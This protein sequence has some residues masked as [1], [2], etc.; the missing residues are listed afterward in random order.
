MSITT[1]YDTIFSKYGNGL[2]VPYL[3]A[4][5]SRESDMNPL[6][7]KGTTSAAKGL[8]QVIPVVLK[9]YNEEHGTKLKESD[10]YTPIVNVAIA[11]STMKH[12]L[13]SYSMSPPLAEVDWSSK[14]WVELFTF[15]WNA[16]YSLAAG[17]AKVATE[18]SKAGISDSDVTIETVSSF[19]SKLIQDGNNVSSNLTNQAK[20]SWCK[21]VVSLYFK[22]LG[23]S[24]GNKLAS[25][26]GKVMAGIS[27]LSAVLGVFGIVSFFRK[28]RNFND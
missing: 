23:I 17:V 28:V 1:K 18:M 24:P 16:G 9:D 10:L 11:T 13:K 27:V 20:V 19:A 8:L 6:S 26:S 7:G 2:P 12:I 14:R 22:E 3:R 4:L 21:G 15:G 5:A 25:K